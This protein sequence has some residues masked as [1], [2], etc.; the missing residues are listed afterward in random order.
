MSNRTLFLLTGLVVLCIVILLLLNALPLF[1]TPSV[2]K[3]LKFNDVRGMAVEHK[4]KLYT[5]N[6]DQQNEVIGYLNKSIPVA[7]TVV[8]NK[9]PKIDI[10]K[11]VVYRFGLP[12]LTMV[13]IEY[14][15]N[16]LIFS[17]P[18][19]NPKGLMK[20]VSRGELENVLSQ[21]YDP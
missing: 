4:G 3:Y 7:D 8:A 13:P 21:T 10:S 18:D 19:W 20:D 12:N 17:S 9:N 15:N 6:F 16:N 11:I 5:L 2:E 1:W 14:I